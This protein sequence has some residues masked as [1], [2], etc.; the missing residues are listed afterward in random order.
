MLVGADDKTRKPLKTKIEFMTAAA[1]PPAATLAL[2]ET[3]GF[4]VHHVYGL[5][6]TYGPAVVNA[7]HDEWDAHDLG[8][9]A[10]IKARQ[11]VRYAVLEDLKKKHIYRD[12]ACIE[13]RDDAFGRVVEFGRNENDL[14]RLVE[15]LLV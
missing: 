4:Q 14:M 8:T 11:G 3:S 9:R 10:Q 6:E 2:M 12:L 1:P 7:W 13:V 5:T 15:S